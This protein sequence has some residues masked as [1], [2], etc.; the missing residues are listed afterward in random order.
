MSGNAINL[1]L[2]GF[3]ELEAKLLTLG[4]KVAKKVLRS[5]VNSSANPI[6]KAARANVPVRYGLLKQSIGVKTRTYQ[7]GTVAAVIGPRGGFRQVVDGVMQDPVNY[8]HLVEYG[9]A[10][11]VIIPESKMALSWDDETFGHAVVG[12]ANHPGTAAQPWL[13]P[14]FY[15]QKDAALQRLSDRLGIGIE[16]EATR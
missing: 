9:T 11:H 4:S 1:K 15:S 3:D 8:A 7:N 10:P 5:A 16:R 12:Q 14:A 6:L 2:V 13:R